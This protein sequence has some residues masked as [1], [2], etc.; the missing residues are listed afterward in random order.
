MTR[1]RLGH[2]EL[3]ARIDRLVAD[4]A[5]EGDHRN[6]DLVAEMV[7]TALRLQRDHADR[8]DVKLIN[9]ALKEMRFS[10][11]AFAPY[12]GSRKVSI[13][14]SARTP[15]D[16][17]NY[18][19]A[20]D[21]ARLMAERRWMVMTGAGP[22]IMEA[23]NLGAGERSFGINIRLP[24]EDAANPY[25]PPERLINFKYFFPRKLAFVKES[26]A[27]ALFP[28]GFGTQDEA[29]ETMTLM[30]TG[31]SDLHP[32]VLIEA[33]G[34]SY[35]QSWIEFVEHSLLER[36]MIQPDDLSLFH[37]TNDVEE[38]ADVIC[39]F[40]DNYHSQRFVDGRLVLRLQYRPD[41]GQMQEINDTFA[42][43]VVDGAIERIEATPIEVEDGDQPDL[44][45]I[46]FHFNRRS[47]GRLRSLID[48]LNSLA[49]GSGSNH[50]D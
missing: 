29:Y 41:D 46:R 3:D 21:L 15:S 10:F 28:G 27:F 42:D 39:S 44:P 13:F 22:G 4:A 37:Y 38:A 48:H 34:T 11:Q 6:A 18:L 45:R 17:P 12:R 23:A 30:Q 5:V 47:L 40:Y 43:I 35:W 33:P 26:H 19:M 50:S 16:E 8:G 31:K 7:V 49:P 36:G 20:T 14:G 2:D 24:F 32:V 1:Y 9:T 25:V